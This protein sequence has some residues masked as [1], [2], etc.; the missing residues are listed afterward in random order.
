MALIATMATAAGHRQARTCVPAPAPGVMPASA[1]WFRMYVTGSDVRDPRAAIP[2]QAR[3]QH[4][5][6]RRGRRR[7]EGR[8][9]GFTRDDRSQRLAHVLALERSLSGEHFE[10]HAAERPDV[11]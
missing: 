11:A 2:C 7:G 4:R 3:A 5:D 1:W 10:Q 8:P 9:V 6:D